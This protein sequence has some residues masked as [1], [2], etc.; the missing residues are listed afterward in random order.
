MVEDGGSE[1]STTKP[2]FVK[3]NPIPMEKQVFTYFDTVPFVLLL[4]LL[5]SHPR[6][7]RHKLIAY[8]SPLDPDQTDLDPHQSCRT[9]PPLRLVPQEPP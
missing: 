1:Q 5:L 8:W 2:K 3:K 4:L 7:L 6:R 9:P